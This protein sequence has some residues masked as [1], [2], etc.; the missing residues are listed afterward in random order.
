[1]ANAIF[2]LLTFV[3]TQNRWKKPF[4]VDFGF[5]QLSCSDSGA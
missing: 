1:V 3:I 5:W 2:C 4:F